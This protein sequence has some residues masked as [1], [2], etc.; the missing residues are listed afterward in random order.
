[1][2]FFSFLPTIPAST[3]RARTRDDDDDDDDDDAIPL[4]AYLD[5]T[6]YSTLC[7]LF[8]SG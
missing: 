6:I 8:E 3:T 4:A 5:L 1:M 2:F 7:L